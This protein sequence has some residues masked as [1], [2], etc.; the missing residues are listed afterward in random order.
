M[1]WRVGSGGF[2]RLSFTNAWVDERGNRTPVLQSEAIYFVRG[3]AV[4]GVWID[5]R[6]QRIQLDAFVNDSSLVTTWTAERERGRTEY[7]VRSSTELLVRDL[8][9]IDGEFQLFGEARYTKR[10]PQP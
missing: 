3:S 10:D 4:Q 1:E 5:S 9:E 8:V 7:M 2:V 6:P